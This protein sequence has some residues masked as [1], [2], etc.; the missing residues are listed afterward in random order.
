MG[1]KLT[2]NEIKKVDGKNY[3]QKKIEV[4]GYEI[5][6]DEKFRPTK[7]HRM[8]LEFLEKMEYARENNINLNLLDYYPLLLMKYF[9]N[10]P[11]PDEL[12]KQIVVYEY[13]IDN[14]FFE[15]I[16]KSFPKEEI[17]KTV[18]HVR[19]FADNYKQLVNNSDFLQGLL[20]AEG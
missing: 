2:Y 17:K 9:T 14:G 19:N 1:K 18:E 13:L 4:N 7:I 15:E 8:I 10:I 3:T 12:E 11:I 20:E 6:I 16:I 5:L